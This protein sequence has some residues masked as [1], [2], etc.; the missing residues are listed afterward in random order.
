MLYT[1]LTVIDDGIVQCVTPKIPKQTSMSLQFQPLNNISHQ[2]VINPFSKTRTLK[3]FKSPSI[4]SVSPTK[5]NPTVSAFDMTVQLHS[6]LDSE[7]QTAV[8]CRL[9][10]S[11]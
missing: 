10:Y 9:S 4:V 3:F 6:E 1:E 11:E 2:I 5:I 8:V 7:L